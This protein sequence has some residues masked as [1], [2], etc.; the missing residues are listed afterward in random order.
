MNQMRL[1]LGTP[2]WIQSDTDPLGA[3]P[4]EPRRRSIGFRTSLNPRCK[5]G[6]PR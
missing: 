2:T 5:K 3:F 6:P 1:V 4:T